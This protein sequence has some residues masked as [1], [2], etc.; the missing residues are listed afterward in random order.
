M[1]RK[2]TVFRPALVAALCGVAAVGALALNPV[3]SAADSTPSFSS[4]YVSLSLAGG[5]PFVAYSHGAGT[6][7]YSA[8]EG[9]THIDSTFVTTPGNSCDIRTGTGFI[10]SYDNHVNDWYSTDNGLTWSRAIDDPAATG[11]S[12][13]SVT[14]DESNVMYNTGIDLANDALFATTDGGKTWITANPQCTQGDRP[15]LGGGKAGEVF[16]GTDLELSNHQVFKGFLEGAGGVNPT[17]VCST[18]GIPDPAA[19]SDTGIGSPLAYDHTTGD[20]IEPAKFAGPKIGLAVLANASAAFGASPT[21]TPTGSFVTR[22]DNAFTTSFLDPIGTRLAVTPPNPSHDNTIYVVWGD[23]QRTTGTNGC[24]GASS[25]GGPTPAPNSILMAYTPDEGQ[26]WFGPFTI[27]HPGTTVIWPWAVVGAAGNLSVTWYQ[28]DQVTDPDCDSASLV[29]G[30][31]PTQWTV[32]V[33]NIFGANSGA[34]YPPAAVNAV[35]P[36]TLHPGGVFHVGGICQSGT[37]CAATGQDRRVGDYF[38]NS[39][40]QNGCVMIATGDTQMTDPTTH[41]Q[42]ATSR[43]LFLHQVGGNSLTTGAPCAAPAVSTPEAPWVPAMAGIG[44]LGAAAVA[45]ARRR[46]RLTAAE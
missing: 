43:P 33:A 34:T 20:L 42:F 9:T 37:T 16:L 32:Q 7:V 12:D 26:T 24:G 39:L 46:R 30:G 28:A 22:P 6:L 38:T 40:D 25:L 10:C 19:A 41:Q 17:I 31:H 36:D 15:W 21:A 1:N 44:G 14:E 2:G 27:A 5:E 29:Q 18:K 3:R 23:D 8:H 45:I 4:D 13:P 35:P 11:F